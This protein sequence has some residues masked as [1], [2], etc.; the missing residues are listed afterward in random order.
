MRGSAIPH[1]ASRAYARAQVPQVVKP[2]EK[3]PNLLFIYACEGAR[4]RGGRTLRVRVCRS[5]IVAC[6]T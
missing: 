4:V 2:E 6:S 5:A 3:D 1:D